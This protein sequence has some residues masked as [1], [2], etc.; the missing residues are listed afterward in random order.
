MTNSLACDQATD[1][2]ISAGPA[3]AAVVVD[4]GGVGGQRVISP[5]LGREIGLLRFDG[6]RGCH[7]RGCGLGWVAE[8]G[9]R[10]WAG[11]RFWRQTVAYGRGLK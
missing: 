8:A 3:L 5:R 7:W 1:G 9:G 4:V 6:R 10:W 2:L 11:C